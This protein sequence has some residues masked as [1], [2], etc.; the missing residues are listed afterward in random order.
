LNE[1]RSFKIKNSVSCNIFQDN[2]ESSNFPVLT[3]LG[4]RNVRERDLRHHCKTVIV[5]FEFDSE[6]FGLLWV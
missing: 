5:A 2:F 1:K 3:L 4:I 6:A